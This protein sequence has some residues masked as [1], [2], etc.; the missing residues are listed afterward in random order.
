MKLSVLLILLLCCA[1]AFA[2]DKVLPMDESG[3]YTFLEV[4]ELP[5]VSKSV[6][7]ANVKRFFKTNSKSLKLSNN[8][9][10]TVFYGK[11]RMIIQKAVVG[12]GH[13]SGEVNYSVNIA[14]REGKYRLI[15]T[16][17]VLTPYERDRYSNYVPGTG[18]SPLE[19]R[20]GKLNLAEWES[21]LSSV[22]LGARKMADKLKLA[23]G[24]TQLEPKQESKKPAVI[25]TK[26]W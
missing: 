3:K 1:G 2:Q 24:N 20:P 16:D 7:P 13:P 14:L 25:S 9:K 19:N 18:S 6:M 22:A 5:L 26:S 10:D 17:F 21:N 11:G 23:M 4:V 12:I 15:L 8:E